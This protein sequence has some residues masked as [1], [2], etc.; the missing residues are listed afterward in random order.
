MPSSAEG[1]A[2]MDDSNTQPAETP[3]PTGEQ[4]HVAPMFGPSAPAQI[5]EP[6]DPKAIF[7][8]LDEWLA[9]ESGYDEEVWPQLKAA[10]E[11]NRQGSR[12]LFRE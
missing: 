1:D 5:R 4:P 9:D 10:L 8:L 7:Q 6:A 3:Q 2:T 12:S 11:R